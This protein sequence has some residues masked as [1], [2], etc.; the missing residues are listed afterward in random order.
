MRHEA[1][2]ERSQRQTISGGGCRVLTFIVREMRLILVHF[3]S[4]PSSHQQ[5]VPVFSKRDRDRCNVRSN[6]EKFSPQQ[7]EIVR[8]VNASTFVRCNNVSI[9]KCTPSGLTEWTS[10]QKEME[11]S[12]SNVTYYQDLEPTPSLRST[13][14]ETFPFTI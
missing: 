12:K 1:V 8:Y 6:Q 4:S 5:Q 14:F 2:V 3:F 13:A 11:S 9:F 10:V 7:E